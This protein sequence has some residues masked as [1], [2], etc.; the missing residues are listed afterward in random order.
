MQATVKVDE[1]D[2][3]APVFS[4]VGGSAQGLSDMVWF[5]GIIWGKST[6]CCT[7]YFSPYSRVAND[8]GGTIVATAPTT[9]S[10][11]SVTGSVVAGDQHLTWPAISGANK[12]QVIQTVF[13]GSTVTTTYIGSTSSTSW[14]Q[15]LLYAT[16]YTGTTQPSSGT[17][18]KFSV[19]ALGT[20]ALSQPSTPVYFQTGTCSGRC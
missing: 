2:S 8:M 20:V 17:W 15:S 13:D 7:S 3:G 19:Y 1:G 16:A 6:D 18:V 5:S 14:T 9:L 10:T 11:P 12:Y 4:L